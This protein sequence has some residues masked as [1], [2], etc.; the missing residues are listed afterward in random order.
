ML[1]EAEAEPGAGI[2]LAMEGIAAVASGF[3]VRDA[4]IMRLVAQARMSLSEPLLRR[5]I[6]GRPSTCNGSA[7]PVQQARSNRACCLLRYHSEKAA[8][9]A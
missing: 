7:F 2:G 5:G 4:L 3:G 9:Q 1:P 8:R 6:S